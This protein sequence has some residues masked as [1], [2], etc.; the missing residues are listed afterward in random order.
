MLHDK[1]IP[2]NV[3]T[4]RPI[5]WEN[6]CVGPATADAGKTKVAGLAHDASIACAC[7]PKRRK[8]GFSRFIIQNSVVEERLKID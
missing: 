5:P 6:R 3:S 2:R 4:M 7:S 8:T 1:A